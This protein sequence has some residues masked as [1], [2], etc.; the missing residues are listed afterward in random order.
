MRFLPVAL[1]VARKDL[2]AEWRGREVLPAL[3][4]FVVLALV[5]ANFSFDIDH[6]SGPRIGP[7]V[8][9]LVIAFA[10]LLAFGRAF[11]AEREGGTLEAMLLTAAGP[12]AILAGKALAAAAV[13]VACELLLLPAMAVF[14]G[15]PLSPAVFATVLVST[16]GM[17]AIGC[18]FAALA[19]RTRARELLLP[20]LVLPLW[21]PFVVVGGRAV[22]AA[23][24]G[25]P[26]GVQ[27]LGV[28]VD[29]DIL[30]LVVACLAARFVLDD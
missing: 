19:A 8:I 30:F 4:Q 10:G 9:W 15:A 14:L 23:M 20:A 22:A 1:A 27:P 16:A 17:S 3:A 29:F 25:A 2:R 18:L 13:L 21:L 5:I 12:A 24:A 11:A 6:A 7:G 26:L 28:L